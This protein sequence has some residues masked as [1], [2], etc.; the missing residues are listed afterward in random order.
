[1]LAQPIQRKNL[2]QNWMQNGDL[3]N[4]ELCEILEFGPLLDSF[5]KIALLDEHLVKKTSIRIWKENKKFKF[6]NFPSL[7]YKKTVMN[8]LHFSVQC[9]TDDGHQVIWNS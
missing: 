1:L 4:F 5:S 3:F 8:A 6:W 9:M 7:L 2:H